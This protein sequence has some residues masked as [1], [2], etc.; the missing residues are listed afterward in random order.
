M[1]TNYD[2]VAIT[3][4]DNGCIVEAIV[5]FYEGDYVAVKK[6][7]YETME[8]VD[9]IEY[10]RMNRLRTVVYTQKDFGTIFS[11]EDMCTF[12]GTKLRGD[13]DRTPIDEQ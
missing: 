7:D 3:R 11:D 8:M 10:K 5:D 13:K 6:R 4:D 12:L 9:A 2:F 1:R